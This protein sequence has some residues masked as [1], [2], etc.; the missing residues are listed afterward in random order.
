MKNIKN[1]SVFDPVTGF[2]GNGQGPYG[3]IADG[4]FAN[5]T[6]RFMSD[7][8]TTQYCIIRQMN[9]CPFSGAGQA[10][11]D[12]CFSMKSFSDVTHC[13]EGR[14]HSAGHAG[15]GGV[16]SQHWNAL[17][18]PSASTRICALI[19]LTLVCGRWSTLSSVLETRSSTSII[20]I[21]IAYG[22]DGRPWIS[23]SD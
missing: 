12:L 14:P 13:W 17:L 18:E 7:L 5:T 20:R 2:G 21:W 6:L 23:R 9:N 11:L 3:C 8:N 10:S 1:A 22:G 4:P 19:S 15:V 16:V